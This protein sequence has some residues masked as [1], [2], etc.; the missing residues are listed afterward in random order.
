MAALGAMTVSVEMVDRICCSLMVNLKP[1]SSAMLSQVPLGLSVGSRTVAGCHDCGR[2]V[3]WACLQRLK[4]ADPWK[5]LFPEPALFG[6][7]LS[8][9]SR[10]VRTFC[11]DELTPVVLTMEQA[12][13]S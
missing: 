3:S 7:S 12:L 5:P 1:F 8:Y 10:L 13:D 6:I 2:P 11:C 9:P 4:L